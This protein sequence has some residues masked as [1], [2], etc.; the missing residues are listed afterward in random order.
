MIPSCPML[1][2]CLLTVVSRPSYGV[3]LTHAR[4][5]LA[6]WKEDYNH[7][8]LHF[9][10]GGATPGETEMQPQRKP[11]QDMPRPGLPSPP[12]SGIKTHRDSAN[13][14]KKPRSQVTGGQHREAFLAGEAGLQRRLDTPCSDSLESLPDRS[15]RQSQPIHFRLLP[16]RLAFWCWVSL[17]LLLL[18]RCKEA[19]CWAL[20]GDGSHHPLLQS[21]PCAWEE[22]PSSV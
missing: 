14:R 15:S 6:A 16:Q 2:L 4:T 3:T 22:T 5:V 7:V 8:R 10:L 19:H 9:G 21:L 18:M 1:R 20:N 17:E 12:A 13:D 11:G